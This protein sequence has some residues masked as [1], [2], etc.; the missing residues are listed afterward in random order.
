MNVVEQPPTVRFQHGNKPMFGL[1]ATVL[2]MLV[3]FSSSGPS[4]LRD[5]TS[6]EPFRP[7]K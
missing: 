7:K 5:G 2:L 6:A 4:Y 3:S 1:I